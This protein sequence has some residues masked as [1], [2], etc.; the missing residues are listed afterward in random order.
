[1]RIETKTRRSINIYIYIYKTGK[2]IK[3]I[4]LEPCIGSIAKYK[5]SDKRDN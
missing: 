3:S 2:L 4:K 1:M 5:T